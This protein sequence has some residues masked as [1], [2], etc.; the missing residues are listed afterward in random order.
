MIKVVHVVSDTNIGGAGR[1]II[2]FLKEVDKQQFDA[3]IVI[4]Q[5]GLLKEQITALRGH[6]I[7]IPGMAD[8]S[9]DM[10]SIWYLYQ[11]FK[12]HNPDIVHTH[13]SLSARIAARCAKVKKIIYTKHCIDA[14]VTTGIKQKLITKMNIWL[15]DY[16]IAVAMAAK[17]GLVASGLP[18]DRIKVLHNGVDKLS[19]ISKQERN[20]YRDKWGISTDEV[21]V[22][23]V[24][25][26]E[27]VKD[28]ATF[29]KAAH[30]VLKR[31]NE[32]KF[33]IVGT[34]AQEKTLKELVK[35]LGRLKNIIFTGHTHDVTAVMNSI[36]IHVISSK[37]EA[38]CLS[39]I[40]AMSV[41]KPGIATRTG[42]NPELIEDSENG[43]L[44]PVGDIQALADAMEKLIKDKPLRQMMG[45]KSEQKM[46]EHF[47]AHGMVKK[48][49]ALYIERIKQ[50]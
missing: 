24:A 28:H 36:D 4:P 12:K 30:E 31:G 16:I 33:I 26:L 25:R 29:V 19:K 15:S 45:Q 37:S 23:I 10:K 42:G 6:V 18:A 2:N 46:E 9:V 43:L 14:V 5:G 17:E 7:E 1:W 21:L 38:L 35:Q 40:E 48:L 50:D 11:L 27:E 20:I 32:A 34:G 49:E 13:A 39:I 41:G 47:T 8:R 44:V 3:S 22:G